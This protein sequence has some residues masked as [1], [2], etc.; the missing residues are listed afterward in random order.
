[1]ARVT[2]QGTLL[3]RALQTDSDTRDEPCPSRF[4]GRSMGFHFSS[5]QYTADAD[6]GPFPG[7]FRS[8]SVHAKEGDSDNMKESCQ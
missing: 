3:A 6:F 5:I 4:P 1:M 2:V 7:V 8:D